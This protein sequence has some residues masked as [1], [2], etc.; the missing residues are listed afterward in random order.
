MTL[1]ELPLPGPEALRMQAPDIHASSSPLSCRQ[2]IEARAVINPMLACETARPIDTLESSHRGNAADSTLANFLLPL[3]RTTFAGEIPD[4]EKP[5]KTSCFQGLCL[6][7]EI[8]F[9]PTTF[10][11][12][13]RRS[14]ETTSP[15]PNQRDRKQ[16]RSQDD[17]RSR[18]RSIRS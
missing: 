9:E 13:D 8:G 18:P 17:H 11:L 4:S 3:P 16:T 14:A 12:G 6:V 10:R 15:N 1:F 2:Q 7:T 5:L